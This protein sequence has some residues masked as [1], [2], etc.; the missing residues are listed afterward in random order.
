MKTTQKERDPIYNLH[1][2]MKIRGFSSKT[3]KSYLYFNI[4]L[5]K[6][7]NKSAKCVGQSDIKEYLYQLNQRQLSNATLSV[8][9]NAIKFYYSK[10]LKRKFF[11]GKEIVRAKKA[12][13]IPVVLTKDEVK[14]VLGAVTNV[15]HKLMLALLYS[16]GLRVSEVTRVKVRDFDLAGRLLFVRG[17]KGAKDRTT[18]L[19]EKLVVVMGRYIN[20]YLKSPLPPFAKGGTACRYVFESERGGKL[21]ERTVQ[22]VFAAALAN[23]GVKKTASCHALRHSFATHLLE[24]GTDIRYIQELLGHQKLETTQIY[25]KVANNNLQNIKNPLD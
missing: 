10:I 22:K 7:A 13:K 21:T 5:I 14:L 4:D 8:A 23:S 2:E 9:F 6:F 15:K 1:R 11:L 25:T 19:S 12:A 24:A 18:I 20:V 3:I 17:A 16:S